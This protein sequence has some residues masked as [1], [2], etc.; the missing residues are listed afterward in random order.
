MPLRLAWLTDSSV[1][2]MKHATFSS[3]KSEKRHG[4]EPRHYQNLLYRIL[5]VEDFDGAAHT[6]AL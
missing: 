5:L 2:S 6:L 4:F 1:S 3:D